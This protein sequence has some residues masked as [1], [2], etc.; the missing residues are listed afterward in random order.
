[1]ILA[2]ALNQ[3]HHGQLPFSTMNRT[4][5]RRESQRT[6]LHHAHAARTSLLGAPFGAADVA[7]M[8]ERQGR[9]SVC[10]NGRT[11]GLLTRV[12]NGW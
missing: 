8:E 6:G 7:T 10:L 5:W 4:H 1:M 9:R 11:M 12:D 3:I 2:K